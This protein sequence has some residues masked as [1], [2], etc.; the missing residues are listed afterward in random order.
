MQDAA[1]QIGVDLAL[2][3]GNPV[4]AVEEVAVHAQV[5]EEVP[6]L[7]DD[8]DT[9]AAWGNIDAPA[10]IEEGLAIEAD[11]AG[12]GAEQTGE[13][14]H[15]SRFAAAGRAENPHPFSGHRKIGGKAKISQT[16]LDR[17]LQLH[18]RL[19]RLKRRTSFSL[20][21]RTAN[22]RAME[23]RH[24]VRAMRSPPGVLV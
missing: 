9:A 12:I 23:T 1:E 6:L 7:K 8:G 15:E 24:R 3:A 13:Q 4:V 11:A 14:V 2:A 16:F 18:R 10:G 17:H 20:S 19:L 22:E 21:S 5:W